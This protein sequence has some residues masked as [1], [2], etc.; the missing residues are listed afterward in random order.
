MGDGHFDHNVDEWGLSPR[1]RPRTD[2]EVGRAKAIDLGLGQS[3]V[4]SRVYH[5]VDVAKVDPLSPAI[6]PLTNPAERLVR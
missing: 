5:V 2:D 6:A 4:R 3:A 1:R